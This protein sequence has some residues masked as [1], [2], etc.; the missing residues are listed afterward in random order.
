MEALE[1]IKQKTECAI[2]T[3]VERARAM[4]LTKLAPQ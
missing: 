4:I 3:P 1:F 2:T